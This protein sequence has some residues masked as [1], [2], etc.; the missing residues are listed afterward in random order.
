M[1][2]RRGAKNRRL[3]AAD[4]GVV[5]RRV[6][7]GDR[8]YDSVAQCSRVLRISAFRIRIYCK[9]RRYDFRYGDKS[10]EEI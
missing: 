6:I 10:E 2:S 3:M 4:D 1:T 5:N 9:D 7:V 8:V